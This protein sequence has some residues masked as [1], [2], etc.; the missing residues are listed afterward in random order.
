MN[1]MKLLFSG[2]ERER[3]SK[4][5][6]SIYGLVYVRAHKLTFWFVHFVYNLQSIPP[7]EYAPEHKLL[8]W[9]MGIG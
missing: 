2:T 8:I 4:A 6:Q 1:G 5:E 7:Y 3:K 9:K